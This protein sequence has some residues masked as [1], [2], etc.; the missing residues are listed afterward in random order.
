MYGTTL[1]IIV[2]RKQIAFGFK[3][4]GENADA[5]VFLKQ[6]FS[7]L[8]EMLDCREL[9]FAIM[10]LFLLIVLS[11]ILIIIKLGWLPKYS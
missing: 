3:E 5:Q 6:M 4:P 9:N 2:I 10:L 8:T 11:G 1:F 7:R